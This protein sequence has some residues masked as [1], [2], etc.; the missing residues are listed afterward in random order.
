MGKIRILEW[1]ETDWKSFEKKL[2][3]K[4][5]GPFS[6][7]YTKRGVYSVCFDDVL[8]RKVKCEELTAMALSKEFI[9]QL[10]RDKITCEN[11]SPRN[12]VG[13]KKCRVQRR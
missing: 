1:L 4:S 8:L 13:G 6:F 7:T 5:F 3:I 9:D 10:K 11:Y 12:S 2:I